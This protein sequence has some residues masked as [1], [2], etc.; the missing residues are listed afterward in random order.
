MSKNRDALLNYVHADNAEYTL[1]T[2]LRWLKDSVIGEFLADEIP[3]L[4]E[5]DKK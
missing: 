4:V 5:G 2:L 1:Q 3:F